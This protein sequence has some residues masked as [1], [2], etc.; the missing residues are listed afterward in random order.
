MAEAGG[1][2]WDA[3]GFARLRAHVA[4]GLVERTEVVV[5]QVVRVLDAARDVERRLE[6]LARSPAFAEARDDVAAQLERLVH[7]GF[8]AATGAAR[9]RRRR[10]L[11]ARRG[12]AAGAAPGRARPGPRQAARRPGARARVRRAGRQLAR[13]PAAP[14]RAARH[15]VAARGAARRALRPGPGRARAGVGQADPARDPRGRARLTTAGSARRRAARPCPGRCRPQR[16]ARRWR[17]RSQ[18]SSSSTWIASSRALSAARASTSDASPS[19]RERSVCSSAT[20]DS[21]R[22]VTDSSAMRGRLLRRRDRIEIRGPMT[23]RLPAAAPYPGDRRARRAGARRRAWSGSSR[24]TTRRR[25]A[26]IPA[27]ASWPPRRGRRC[28]PRGR[29]GRP[30]RRDRDRLGERRAQ[31]AAGARIPTA[32]ARRSSPTSRSRRRSA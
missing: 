31:P 32:T 12:A 14:A 26:S 17:S 29:R 16:R 7:P 15:P 20:S 13:R 2:A 25:S 4:G 5:R 22:C 1:P 21:I 9:L 30:R 18:H 23:T 10:A 27:S 11:P 6:P 24:S 28:R 8:V 19:S 3:E